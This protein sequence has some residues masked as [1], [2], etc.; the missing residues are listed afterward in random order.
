MVNLIHPAV[1]GTVIVNLIDL[2]VSRKLFAQPLPD[3]RQ[4]GTRLVL[5]PRLLGDY[6]HVRR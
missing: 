6:Y 5:H 2:L 4:C 1:L 3:P